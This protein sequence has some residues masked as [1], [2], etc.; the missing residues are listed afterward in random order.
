MSNQVYVIGWC[1]AYGTQYQ[2]KT[3]TP[4][5]RM[6]LV[7]CMRKRKYSFGHTDH[8]FLPY[9]APVYNDKTICVLNKLQWDGIIA[10]VYKDMPKAPR[11]L[12]MDVITTPAK[13]EILFEKEKYMKMEDYSNV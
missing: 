7:E 1:S 12:P 11:K 8:S 5:R 6:A 10:E 3:F 4:E 9:C 13:N 2:Q